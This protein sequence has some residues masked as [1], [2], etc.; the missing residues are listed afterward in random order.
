MTINIKKTLAKKYN[1]EPICSNHKERRKE[2]KPQNSLQILRTNS[3]NIFNPTSNELILQN[4]N[5]EMKKIP[6]LILEVFNNDDSVQ[7]Y[8]NKLLQILKTKFKNKIKFCKTLVSSNNMQ[9]Y[10]EYLLLNKT[11]IFPSIIIDEINGEQTMIVNLM[12][13]IAKIKLMIPKESKILDNI[14]FETIIKSD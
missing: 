7:I 8:F 2:S 13:T 6:T 14:I 4:I 3:L 11:K 1:S 9:Y 10:C 5:G 12:D